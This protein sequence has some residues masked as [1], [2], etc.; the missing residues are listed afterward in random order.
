[1]LTRCMFKTSKKIADKIPLCKSIILTTMSTDLHTSS[2][3]NYH[4]HNNAVP[5]LWTI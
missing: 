2:Y 3:I 5:A 1:M 4:L